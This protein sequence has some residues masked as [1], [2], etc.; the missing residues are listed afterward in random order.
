VYYS[1]Y[2]T[3]CTVQQLETSLLRRR[4]AQAFLALFFRVLSHF[5]MYLPD[6]ELQGDGIHGVVPCLCLW[7]ELSSSQDGFGDSSDAAGLERGRPQ[8]D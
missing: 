4:A 3:V 6:V 8:P 5:E 7:V 2:C 1:Y